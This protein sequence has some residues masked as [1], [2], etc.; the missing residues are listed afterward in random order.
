[1]TKKQLPWGSKFELSQHRALGPGF[2]SGPAQF[3]TQ[4][5]CSCLKF[6]M[7]MCFLKL[8]LICPSLS[9]NCQNINKRYLACLAK[10]ASKQ[11]IKQMINWLPWG[12]GKKGLKQNLY[13]NKK[14]FETDFG[15]FFFFLRWKNAISKQ[16]LDWNLLIDS[17]W[18]CAKR[19]WCLEMIKICLRGLGIGNNTKKI[20]NWHRICSELTLRKR[21]NFGKKV[22]W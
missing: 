8:C 15:R 22:L 13:V 10:R 7:K 19:F 11:I 21:Q 18:S 20:K 12:L 1:M 6:D 9:E 17:A 5:H 4:K 14:R 2:K 16:G 3:L